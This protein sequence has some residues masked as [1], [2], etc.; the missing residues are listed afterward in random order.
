MTIAL[1]SQNLKLIPLIYAT[2]FIDDRLSIG[3]FCGNR[4][5]NEGVGLKVQG[6]K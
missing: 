2:D 6:K 1:T 3:A 4:L 5:K